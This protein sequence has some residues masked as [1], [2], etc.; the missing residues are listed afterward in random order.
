[1]LHVFTTDGG[2]LRWAK[3]AESRPEPLPPSTLWLDLMNPTPDEAAR[4][5]ALMGVKLPTREQ[6][7]EIEE[8]SRL[9]VLP[10]AIHMTAMVVIRADTDRPRL[11]PITFILAGRRIA[12]IHHYDP[13][14][15]LDFRRRVAHGGYACAGAEGVLVGLLDGVAERTAIL[16]RRVATDLDLMS[17][18]AF[19]GGT[20]PTRDESPDDAR[21]L[22]RIGH[23]GQLVS[24]VHRSIASLDR[25]LTFIA[26]SEGWT[27]DKATRR[28]SR[29]AQQ[30]VTGLG[31]YADFLSGKVDLLLDG[32]LGQINV[33]QNEIV[34][35]VSILTVAL[36]PPT[37]IA[38]V[39]G[40][41]F[42]HMPE[43]SWPMGYAL[44]FLLMILSGV[45]P[46]LYFKARRWL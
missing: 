14:S 22:K 2:V 24:K 16:L 17:R 43:K 35:L 31:E 13:Q 4:A 46:M 12:T 10:G 21:T 28:W 40:M 32:T 30:D 42:G 8:S 3:G 15:F 7:A 26:R 37:L 23:T 6:M 44:A 27:P 18:R 29:A 33:E 41:N 11:V 36:F 9:R 20:L 1:M 5:E 34:K 39:Y 38:S 19:R 45:L 25:M